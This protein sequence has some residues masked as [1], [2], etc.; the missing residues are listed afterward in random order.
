MNGET[1]LLPCPFCGGKAECYQDEDGYWQVNCKSGWLGLTQKCPGD[2]CIGYSY[3]TE[4]EA[5]EAWNTR[6]DLG[7]GTCEMETSWEI[8]DELGIADAPEDTWGYRCSV[9]GYSFRYDRGIKPNFCP[10]CG[11]R[12]RKK[13]G[14]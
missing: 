13:V 2:S 5:V 3:D 14:E 6:A 12:V 10:N 7:S 8:R 9:C 11:A 4:A 1:T